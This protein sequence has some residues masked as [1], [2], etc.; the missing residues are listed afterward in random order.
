M[1]WRNVLRLISV[2]VKAG[3]IVRGQSFRRFREK[4]ALQY[5]LYGGACFLG[6]A[7]GIC[8][9]V[10]YSGIID[11]ELKTLLFLGATSLFLSF[12]TLVLVFN[13]VFT[14]MSQIQRMGI[15]SSI[16]PPFWLPITWSEHTLASTL[17]SLIGIPLAFVLF[18]SLAIFAASIFLELVPLAVLTIFALLASAFLASITTEIF[19]VLQ[20]RLTG[21][22]YKSSGKAAVWIRFF[23]TM[24]FL[25]MFYIIWFSFTSGTGSIALIEAIA[26]TQQTVWFVPYL[27]LGMSLVSFASGLYMQTVIFGFASLL[28]VLALFYLAVRLNTRFGLYEPPAIRVSRRAYAPKV[29]LLG[30]LGLSSL[31][32]AVI[33][34]DF[35][36]IT[37]RRELLFIFIMPLV[38]D[39]VCR[40]IR[41]ICS[42]WSFPFSFYHYNSW[43][44]S[45]NGCHV[46]FHDNW[47]GRHRCM[48]LLFFPHNCPESS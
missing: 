25:I 12:P 29:G 46:R 24:L 31:E 27:W 35:K 20:V 9:G 28:F 32:T 30:K 3:R 13:V 45:N 43:T 4:R 14:M 41:W 18:S 16:Q 19:R 17:A 5:L 44:S 10:L 7:I 8:V 36:A 2:D 47:R 48:A 37:R 23:G 42:T 22:V 34:K 39:A 40:N 21:A 11:S 38:S 15:S 6:L 33:R 26:G 1:N